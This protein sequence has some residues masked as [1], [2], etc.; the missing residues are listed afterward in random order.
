M[1][2][3]RRPARWLSC[4]LVLLLAWLFVVEHRAPLTPGW[5]MG[6]Q[7]GMV[8]CIY[9]LV[10]LWLRASAVRLLRS[11]RGTS[12]HERAVEPRGMPSS[13][14]RARLAL[15]QAYFFGVRARYPH[16]RIHPEAKRRR[17]RKCSVSFDRRSS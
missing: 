16:R 4:A 5:H 13:L 15:R 3:H 12:Q 1:P 8:L 17:I 7:I 10:W 6:V 9:G 14:S 2:K 11:D